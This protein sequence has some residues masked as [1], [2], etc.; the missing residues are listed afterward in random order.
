MTKIYDNKGAKSC[1][2]VVFSHTTKTKFNEK[3]AGMFDRVIANEP[4]E[5]RRES[6]E[7]TA[8]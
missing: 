4:T 6:G 7:A 8:L 2:T 3:R 1:A 5:R